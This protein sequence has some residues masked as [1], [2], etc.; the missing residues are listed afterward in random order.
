MNEYGRI[1]VCGAISMY[2]DDN[3]APSMAP[4]AEPELVFKQLKM[5]GFLVH[6]WIN[7]WLEGLN[8]MLQWIDE[9]LD[10]AA[11][12][13]RVENRYIKAIFLLWQGKIQVRETATQGFDNM[14][15]AFIDMLQGGNT[16]KAIIYA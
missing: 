1:S 13:C 5:E 3:D 8:Q 10:P 7:R 15:K 9:V 14:P 11:K 4:G 16:G 2:N 12:I 6:R